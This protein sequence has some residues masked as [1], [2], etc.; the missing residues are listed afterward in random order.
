VQGLRPGSPTN[1]S[2]EPDNDAIHVAV[3]RN[4]HVKTPSGVVLVRRSRLEDLAQLHL[5]PPRLRLDEALVDVADAAPRESDAVA[6]LTD[7][8]QRGRSTPARL[9]HVVRGR[10]RLRRRRLLT[11]LLGDVSIGVRSVLER[12]YV[13]DVERPHG[14]PTGR[15]QRRVVTRRGSTYRDV[16]YREQLTVVELD[17]RLVHASVDSRWADLERES[18]PP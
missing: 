3:D 12:R 4:R 13:R 11:E 9:L 6:V 8:C 15:R 18:R 1:R 2:N 5:S 14:L 7:A 17:G 16:E 10:A